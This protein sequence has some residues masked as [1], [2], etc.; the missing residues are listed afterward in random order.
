M[1]GLPWRLSAL[2]PW[3]SL[4]GGLP[5][6]AVCISGQARTLPDTAWK[7]RKRL[8]EPW[9]QF[10]GAA[11][12]VFVS[13]RSYYP[14]WKQA[15]WGGRKWRVPDA[16]MDRA[17]RVLR[18]AAYVV[19]DENATS[20][21]LPPARSTLCSD[22]S[23]EQHWSSQARQFWSIA[24]CFG[25]VAAHE[26]ARGAAFAYFVRFRADAA[27]KARVPLAIGEAR[28]RCDPAARCLFVQPG[29]HSD[30]LALVARAGADAYASTFDE[31]HGGKCATL[32]F[33][34]ARCE[35]ELGVGQHRTECLVLAHMRRGEED[36]RGARGGGGASGDSSVEV[37]TDERFDFDIVRPTD[38]YKPKLTRAPTDGELAWLRE[39]GT[40]P[41][42]QAARYE[43]VPYVPPPRA[44]SDARSSTKRPAR[45]AQPW[46]PH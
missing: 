5:T 33:A 19:Y 12:F 9:E 44:P 43:P 6:A 16:E 38:P 42:P 37:V 2:L 31:F 22:T 20:V 32:S 4:A 15:A 27:P 23:R 8:L 13:R 24:R 41:A 11:S 25:L 14:A 30:G 29:E 3:L 21:E 40:A 34:R 45:S 17:L 18:P 35:R 46:L 28:A 10:G 36:A 39:N 1:R 26:R 7:I